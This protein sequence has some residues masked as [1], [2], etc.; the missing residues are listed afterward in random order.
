MRSRRFFHI[1]AL[2][3]TS[4]SALKRAK[5]DRNTTRIIFCLDRL[6]DILRRRGAGLGIFRGDHKLPADLLDFYQILR[7]QINVR[8]GQ[9]VEYC[10]F[11]FI[12]GSWW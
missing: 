6:R 12:P 11:F 4:S 7:A 9:D 3:K 8:P 2:V 5:I 1:G 10:Q